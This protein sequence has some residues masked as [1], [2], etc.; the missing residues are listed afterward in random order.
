MRNT[1]TSSQNNIQKLRHTN[2]SAPPPRQFQSPWLCAGQSHDE[3]ARTH[4]APVVTHGVVLSRVPALSD[5][6]HRDFRG[7]TTSFAHEAAPPGTHS[8]SRGHSSLGCVSEGYGGCHEPRHGAPLSQLLQAFAS[9]GADWKVCLC[10]NSFCSTA[11]SSQC[12]ECST[13]DTLTS[14][15]AKC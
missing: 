12:R 6:P 13:A 7:G 15:R 9:A 11:V 10:S 5:Y 4:H 1:K 2:Y 3:E 8:S 14:C